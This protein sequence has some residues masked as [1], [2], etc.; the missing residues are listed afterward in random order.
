MHAAAGGVV[1]ATEGCEGHT[2]PQSWEGAPAMSVPGARRCLVPLLEGKEQ[3]L[4]TIPSSSTLP[5]DGRE[6]GVHFHAAPSPH[7]ALFCEGWA[8]DGV[9]GRARAG[10]DTW[11]PCK[12][13]GGTGAWAASRSTHSCPTAPPWHRTAAPGHW[14]LHVTGHVA[15]RGD[16]LRK[17]LHYKRVNKSLS[18][19]CLPRCSKW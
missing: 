17:V 6:M 15:H 2:S 19:P 7:P 11:S 5:W 4:G 9:R 1:G 10:D 14:P 13:W 3:P 18:F 16:L 8:R 12:G